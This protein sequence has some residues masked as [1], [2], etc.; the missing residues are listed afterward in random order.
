MSKEDKFHQWIEEQN[1]EEKAQAFERLK[2][3][4]SLPDVQPTKKA[5]KPLSFWLKRLVPV[6]TAIII[7][8]GIG[9]GTGIYLSSNQQVEKPEEPPQPPQDQTRYCAQSEY[10]KNEVSMT[11]K[12]Y[13]LQNGGNILYFDDYE[14]AE[15]LADHSYTLNDTSEIIA[16]KEEFFNIDREYYISLSITDNL[17]EMD[18]FSL[19][20]NKCVDKTT[21]NNIKVN[22]YFFGEGYTTWE[23]NGYRYYLRSDGPA[24]LEETLAL[25][26][27]LLQK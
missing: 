7:C 13:S 12:E 11:L 2:A 14:V 20:K 24:T 1:Q 21:I 6:C 26:E 5:K 23:Y 4:L 18:E 16:F 19:H 9:I 15:E 17:T 10:T 3:E 22:Y 8:I 25:V 27:E